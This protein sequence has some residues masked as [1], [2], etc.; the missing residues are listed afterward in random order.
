MMQKRRVKEIYS[1][2]EQFD[3]EPGHYGTLDS[4]P[5]KYSEEIGHFIIVFS[6]LEHSI[7]LVIADMA[8]DRAHD[9]GYR[10]VSGLRMRNKIEFLYKIL[11]SF[12]SSTN[13]LRRK[14]KLSKLKD[15]LLDVNEFRNYLAHA[16]WCTLKKNG[17]VRTKIAT[18]NDGY[19]AFKNIKLT[20]IKIGK[21]TSKVDRLIVEVDVFFMNTQNAAL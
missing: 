14:K 8:S 15:E 5:K 12:I 21:M 2:L 20:P 1:S 6:A 10:I 13:Q 4:I 9:L 7:N 18:D 16:N 3:S 17:L 19:V 11:L